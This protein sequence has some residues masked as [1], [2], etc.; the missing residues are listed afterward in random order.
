MKSFFYILLF[1]LPLISH[2]QKSMLNDTEIHK[3]IKKGLDKTYN[4]EFESAKTVYAEV[5]ARYPDHPAYDF[6]MASQLYW[7]MYYYDSHKEQSANYFSHLQQSLSK[8]SKYLEKNP[9]DIEGIFFSMAVESSFA[10]YFA[11]RR[12]YM[13]C[14][15]HAKRAY[16]AMK[17]GFTLKE[18]Y[19]DFYFSTGLYDY[20]VVQYPET[21]PVYKPF[22]VFFA[23][24]NKQRGITEL[25]HAAIHGVFSPTESLHY[26][27]NIY[28]KYENNYQKALTYS[29][30][31]ATKY[32][33]NYYFI[34]RHIEGL[35][36][37]GQ[38]KEA[39]QYTYKLYKTG[40]ESFVT[41]AFI[42]YGMLYEKHYKNPAEA[43]RYYEAGV[44]HANQL[45]QPVYDYLSFAYAGIARIYDSQGNI[46]LA[47]EYYKKAAEIAQ[48][49]SI[50]KESKAYLDKHK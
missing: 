21:N 38:Y 50:K 43:L 46:K 45:T 34:V 30:Q 41:R 9:K 49:T 24:G 6:L 25:E 11:E 12:E 1:L 20:F 19:V 27:A 35:I 47:V 8:A 4:F 13:K 10:L 39:E 32:P 37:T 31:L 23:K 22:M 18:K 48:Y 15:G 16:A 42:F 26:L 5:K 7:E 3:T 14:L 33:D 40:K 2:G 17:E 28:L 44:R 29:Q 36:G